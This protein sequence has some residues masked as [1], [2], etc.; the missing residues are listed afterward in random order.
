VSLEKARGQKFDGGWADYTPPA[1]RQP[2]VTVF[3]DIDLCGVFLVG[4]FADAAV[5]DA[6]ADH[7]LLPSPSGHWMGFRR[8]VRDGDH[9]KFWV[10]GAGTAGFKRDPYA[11]ELSSNPPYPHCNCI[12]RNP[13]AYRWRATNW[14]P[15]DFSD[16]ILYQLHVG[17]FAAANAGVAGSFLDVIGQ[18]G[19]LR[20]L[21][22]TALQLLPVVE[23]ASPRSLGY[24]G[25]DIFSPEMDYTLEGAAAHAYLAAVSDA[26]TR[27]GAAPTS[28]AEIEVPI[29]QLK[30]LVD[31]CHLNGIAVLLDV[32]YNHAGY[33]IRGQDESLYFLDRA[34]GTHP[35]DSLYFMD[36]D[37]TGPVFAF[38]K[39]EVRQFLIDN[40]DFFVREY[41]VDGLRLDHTG[42]I[43]REAVG[44]G[45]LFLQ[46]CTSTVRAT[47]PRVC[48]TAEHWPRNAFVT[49]SPNSGGAGFDATWNDGVR[50]SVRSAVAAASQ[51][52]SGQIDLDWIARELPSPGFREGWR[53]VNC[54]ESHDEVYRD[55]NPRVARLADPS[56]SRSW[57]GRSRAR[58]ATALL[59]VAPGMPMLFMGQEILE[60]K[61]WSD[62]PDHH[63]DTLVWWEG[64]RSGEKPM[65]DMHRCVRE[66]IGLRRSL[67]ALRY[68]FT[69][70]VHVDHSGRV[71]ALHRWIEGRGA[72]VIAVACLREQAHFGYRIGLPQPGAWR[73]VFNSDVYDNWV[74]PQVVGNGGVIES[75]AI[76]WN[77]FAQSAE[78]AVPP[79]ALVV[80]VPTA[81]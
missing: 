66:L 28:A 45:W 37:H 15:P 50:E 25:S 31:L 21:G 68:G 10:N 78:I 54:L 49:E 8:G 27:A 3:D 57:Y 7:A 53:A 69:R 76:P 72:D 24:D 19:Y 48:Q 44:A 22:I 33:Q 35:D 63:P 52:E 26:L 80:L 77:G 34:G 61:N 71:L 12:V 40:A 5:W 60:D 14:R 1:P 18:L 32:V 9:Y 74:N 16:L 58:L 4:Q 56:N 20:D 13:D 29:N 47:N 73:E 39:S 36:R 62:D 2:G 59:M 46:H 67:D 75:S 6:R 43:D 11:R 55:R 81:R 42:V 41:R 23:F 70:I 79:N 30:L 38:W 17:T 64:L 65:V 51:G